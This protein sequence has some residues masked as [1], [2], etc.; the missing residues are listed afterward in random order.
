MNINN[1]ADN[2]SS[3]NSE[4]STEDCNSVVNHDSS[5]NPSPEDICKMYLS[6]HEDQEIT[7]HDFI[8]DFPEK[9]NEKYPN[10]QPYKLLADT[11]SFCVQTENEL[12][13]KFCDKV[14][15]I[16]CLLDHFIPFINVYNYHDSK[17][18]EMRLL[19]IN[20]VYNLFFSYSD[21]I[22]RYVESL[23]DFFSTLVIIMDQGDSLS[24]IE[25]FRCITELYS[26]SNHLF[27]P[28][29]QRLWL[30]RIVAYCP[31]LSQLRF[32]AMNFVSQV[33][34]DDFQFIPLCNVLI[35]RGIEN[36][37]SLLQLET[38]LKLARDEDPFDSYIFLFKLMIQHSYFGQSAVDVICNTIKGFIEDDDDNILIYIIFLFRKVLIFYALA[39][40]NN[41]Y[42]YRQ[43]LVEILYQKI[44][45]MKKIRSFKKSI[46]SILN[47][48]I[49]HGYL[50]DFE[51]K[52]QKSAGIDDLTD[53]FLKEKEFI[54]RSTKKL[55]L[56]ALY[57]FDS[58]I[59][60]A[61]VES[62]NSDQTDSE[63]SYS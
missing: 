36:T 49:K 47:A 45:S 35:K 25:A 7:A 59:D 57:P 50:K 58:E 41:R 9:I 44:I 40:K 15:S 32:M 5:N 48:L 4:Q 55:K 39:K 63:N 8:F 56:F 17:D 6:L 13:K 26:K 2:L 46:Q 51:E 27:T 30:F 11:F 10:S 28:K 16:D 62:I 60:S 43:Y 42:K 20:T 38:Y 53:S 54:A 31:P 14:G 22:S 29:V 21:M 19:L 24:Q 52:A 34:T 61:L 1:T 23:K 12:F 37:D 18:N 3:P 33:Y